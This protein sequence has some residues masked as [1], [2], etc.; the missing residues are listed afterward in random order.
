MD[1]QQLRESLGLPDDASDEQVQEELLKRAG[2]DPNGPQQRSAGVAPHDP[3][4]TG[5][6]A[7]VSTGMPEPTQDNAQP[8]PNPVLPPEAA[9][10]AQPGAV[11]TTVAN[12]PAGMVLIDQNT[13]SE[14]RAGASAGLELRTEM[15]RQNRESLVAAAIGDGRIAP[16]SRDHWLRYLETDPGGEEVLASLAPGLIPVGQQRADGHQQPEMAAASI[17]DDTVHDWT[18]HLFREVGRAEQHEQA[19]AAGSAPRTR[20]SA[21]ANF[22]R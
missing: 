5:G 6:V 17:D 20:I 3:A 11:Q 21:D 12:L 14:I 7:P 1:P 9:S 22:R 16:S 15:A 8:N 18:R 19:V 13:L 10:A 2:I 4:A